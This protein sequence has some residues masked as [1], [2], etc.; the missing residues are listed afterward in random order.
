MATTGEMV[1]ASVRAENVLLGGWVR[2]HKDAILHALDVARQTLR[3][4]SVRLEGGG[5]ACDE[6]S[7]DFRSYVDRIDKAVEAFPID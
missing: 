7:R 5:P 1:E 2:R 3:N 4:D 6:L